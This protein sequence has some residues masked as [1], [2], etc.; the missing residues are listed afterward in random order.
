MN[1]VYWLAEYAAT[2]VELFMCSIFC[3]TFIREN[4]LKGA[5]RQ[6]ILVSAACSFIIVLINNISLFS[7]ITT[8]LNF[9]LH[10][11]SQIILYKRSLFKISILTG[12]FF[13][14]MHIFD[15]IAVSGVSYFMKVSSYD[16]YEK[17]SLYRIIAI[18]VS[19]SLL[20]IFTAAI[21]KIFTKKNNYIAMKNLIILFGLTLFTAVVSFFLTFADINNKTIHSYNSVLIFVII[22]VLLIVILFGLFKLSDYYESQQQLNLTK[23]KNQMLEQS[24]NETEQTFMLWKTSL[25]DFKHKIMH[26]MVLA[27]SDNIDAIKQFL[28]EENK[29]ISKTLFY[30]K[31]GNDTVDTILNVKQR[32][33]EDKGIPFVINAEVSPD[34]PVSSFDFVSILG[35]LID[36][37]IESSV[38]ETNPFIDV[39]IKSIKNM[40]II[41]ISNRCTKSDISLITK[42]TDKHLHGLGLISIKST[43]KKYNGEFDVEISNDT[44]NAKIMIPMKE[45]S[46]LTG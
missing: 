42:K 26:L 16:I 17:M 25:H 31:T 28:N 41:S 46:A 20:I 12:F 40:L 7:P 22:L 24:L 14:I 39:R 11:L 45:K 13:L 30:Y 36:N 18:I 44:F 3:G 10:I 33:A 1:L 21:N 4:D 34:C 23:L 38:N 8:F 29:L 19:K 15:N 9:L 43:V 5:Y 2:F 37:A 6:K 35:N 32:Y 27:E